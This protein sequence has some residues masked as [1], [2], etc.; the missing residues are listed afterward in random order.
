MR[1][2]LRRLA[3]VLALAYLAAGVASAATQQ[4]TKELKGQRQQP[5]RGWR[6]HRSLAATR[7]AP[8]ARPGVHA[9]YRMLITHPMSQQGLHELG[10]HE[11]SPNRVGRVLGTYGITQVRYGKR[12]GREVL[13]IPEISIRQVPDEAKDPMLTLLG[14]V[15]RNFQP[16]VLVVG[17]NA[18]PAATIESWR[19]ASGHHN[20]LA[21]IRRGVDTRAIHKEAADRHRVTVANLPKINS[22]FVAAHMLR[23]L[24]LEHAPPGAAIAVVGTGEIGK[25]IIEEALR[26]GLNVRVYSPSLAHPATRAKAIADKGLDSK[27][28]TIAHTL[29]QAL[30]RAKYVAISVPYFGADGKRL[31]GMLGRAQI[32]RL[33]E[34][35]VIVSASVPMIFSEDSLQTLNR[36]AKNG[37]ARVRID[38]AP[39]HADEVRATYPALEAASNQAF[40]DPAAQLALDRGFVHRA[41]ELMHAARGRRPVPQPRTQASARP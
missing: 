17:N 38:T 19:E 21:V 23:Q 25:P 33:A 35:P 39:R 12:R 28:V 7:A 9:G 2:H 6:L 10:L 22:P 41:D 13:Y 29:D 4:P 27:R 20:A 5:E 14:S 8:F 16:N 40:A 24:R 30:H 11:I 15:L 26:H 34:D 1:F 32:D 36:L 37:R 18:V 31:D 3:S